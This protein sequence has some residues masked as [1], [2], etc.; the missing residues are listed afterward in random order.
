[1][2]STYPFRLLF[3]L[4]LGSGLLLTA[5]CGP[6]EELDFT[7]STGEFTV[8]TLAVDDGCLD[9]GLTPLFMPQG[10]DLAWEW[11]HPVRLYSPSVLPQEYEINLRA[12]FNAVDVRAIEAAP[13]WQRLQVARN[14]SVKLDPE[15]FGE[16]T[17]YLQGSVEIQLISPDRV[18]GLASLEMGDPSGD[19]RCPADMPARCDVQLEFEAERNP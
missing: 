13:D 12:P 2:K 17:A 7:F 3:I 16:C 18:R 15:R 11:P 14:P 5:G 4:L 8:S 9:G 19:D 10:A 6:S 1:M